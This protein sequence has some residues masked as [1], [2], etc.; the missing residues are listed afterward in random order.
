MGIKR[1]LNVIMICEEFE[2][3]EELIE[4]VI[5]QE[6]MNKEIK[7]DKVFEDRKKRMKKRKKGEIEGIYLF[8]E[9]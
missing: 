2:F 8:K 1:Y 4:G 3:V 7:E 9:K 5:N 6:E